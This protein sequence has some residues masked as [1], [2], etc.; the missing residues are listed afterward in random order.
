MDYS[1]MS[2]KEINKLVA[3]ALGCKEVVPD[4]F[5]SDDRRYEFDKPKNKS[6]NKFYF[7]PCNE[8]ADAWP[9]IVLNGIGIKK[10]S[11]GMWCATRQGGLYPQYHENPLRAAMVVFLHMQDSANVPANSTGSDIR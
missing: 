5:M 6:G 7:D 3:F 4:I 11:N 9:I 10:Q 8:V 1:K 2:D